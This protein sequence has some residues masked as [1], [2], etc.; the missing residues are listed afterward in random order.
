M[1]KLEARAVAP[2]PAG[3]VTPLPAGLVGR[4]S[5]SPANLG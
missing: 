2:R 3:V 1:A 5:D 4:R